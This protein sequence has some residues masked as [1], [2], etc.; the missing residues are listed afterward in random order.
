MAEKKLPDLEWFRGRANY[1]KDQDDDRDK[2]FKALD[3]YRHGE[4]SLDEELLEIEWIH[5]SRDPIFAQQ[6]DSAKHILSDVT[7]GISLLPYSPGGDGTDIADKHEKGLRWLLD[8]ASRRRQATI[9]QDVVSSSI[10]YAEVTAQVMYIPQQIKDVKAAGGN[11]QRYEAM[12]RRGPFAVIIHNPQTVNCRYSDLGPEEV[13]LDVQ[14]DPHN[15]ID[16]YGNK[17][18]KLKKW[19]RNMKGKGPGNVRLKNYT[20]YDYHAVWVELGEGGEMVEILREKWLWPFLGWVCRYGGTSLEEKGQF[21]RKPLLANMYHF[22]LYDDINRVRTLRF[23]DMIR[24][25]GRA[26]DVFESDTRTSPDIDASTGDL[27]VHTDTE[28]KIIPQPQEAADPSMSELYA[29]LR[30]DIQKSTLSELL[31]GGDVPSG[32]AFAS[33]DLVTNSALKVLRAPQSLAQ[34]SVA[35]ILET[36]LLYI[37]YDNSQVISYGT[38]KTDRGDE[39]LIRGE[40][41]VPKNL[42]I[43]V[44]LEADLPTDFQARTVTGRAQIDAGINSRLGVMEDTGIKNAT[45]VEEEIVQERLAETMLAV[46]LENIHFTNSAQLQEQMRQQDMEELQNNPELILQLAA[47]L[48]AGQQQQQQGDPQQ[49]LHVQEGVPGTP[50]RGVQQFSGDEIGPD[51]LVPSEANAAEGGPTTEE[52]DPQGIRRAQQEGL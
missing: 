28:E 21:Q 19:L 43:T 36:F 41:I 30:S 8:S 24:K 52:F 14:D 46:E 10:D 49:G 15:I 34:H 38:G 29:E 17:A 4:W 31:L 18:D 16:L 51:S 40:D 3:S 33:I 50:P 1:L 13:V 25:A 11:A 39:Y 48:Q 2:M 42:Y 9:V 22:D 45:E 6:S 23:S 27:Y 44:T 12:L 35:D 32:A 20:S 26:R 5:E 37:H 7:P 47:Q